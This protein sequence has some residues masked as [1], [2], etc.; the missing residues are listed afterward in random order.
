MHFMK[1]GSYQAH[2][3]VIFFHLTIKNRD[4]SRPVHTDV[5]LCLYS[6]HSILLFA[7]ITARLGSPL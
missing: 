4:P 2:Y 1:V 3:P 5:P 7:D 6:S